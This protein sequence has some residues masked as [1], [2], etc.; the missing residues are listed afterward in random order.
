VGVERGVQTMEGLPAD[1]MDDEMDSSRLGRTAS[2]CQAEVVRFS[3]TLGRRSPLCM[4]RR[5][6]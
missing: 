6:V 5:S 4:L 2:M 3:K 1:S